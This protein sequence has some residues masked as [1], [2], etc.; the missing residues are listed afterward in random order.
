M[1]KFDPHELHLQVKKTIDSRE[2]DISLDFSWQY[3][4]LSQA[5]TS[6][7][8][9]QIGFSLRCVGFSKILSFR[10][11]LCNPQPKTVVVLLHSKFFVC[12]QLDTLLWNSTERS[13]RS[14]CWVL[15]TDN[16]QQIGTR[17]IMGSKAARV[18]FI[19]FHI[20]GSRSFMV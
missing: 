15:G 20:I 18:S 11:L 10:L 6:I 13:N 3:K 12:L 2:Y 5:S 17:K 7:T 14:C 1:P 19:E 8:I 9:F 4:F 16:R